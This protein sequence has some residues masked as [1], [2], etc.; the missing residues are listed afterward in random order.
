MDAAI[1]GIQLRCLL[2]Q[3]FDL[4]DR[5]DARPLQQ[6][7]LQHVDDSPVHLLPLQLLLST[8]HYRRVGTIQL[9]GELR[10]RTRS[11]VEHVCYLLV[12]P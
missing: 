7:L 8:L 12:S 4:L 2:D 6:H 11:D 1:R 5:P 3:S 9:R 10:D